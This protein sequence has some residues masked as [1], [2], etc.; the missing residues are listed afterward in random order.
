MIVVLLLSLSPSPNKKYRAVINSIVAKL[1]SA[2]STHYW[3]DAD[4]H[5]LHDDVVPFKGSSVTLPDAS[6][7]QPAQRG[8]LPLSSAFS[9]SAKIATNLPQLKSSS[10]VAVGPLCDDNKLVVFGKKKVIT[11]N[12]SSRIQKALEKEKTL[13]EGIRNTT[14]G[15][16][17][18]NLAK[19]VL[20]PTHPG[21]YTTTSKPSFTACATFS[22]QT[23][24][25]STKP[26]FQNPFCGMEELIKDNEFDNIINSIQ[27][28][29]RITNVVPVSVISPTLNVIICKRTL[30]GDLAEFLHHS[31]FAPVVPTLIKA[32]NNGHLDTFPGLTSNLIRKH[33]RPSIPSAKGHIKQE[34]QNVQKTNNSGYTNILKDIKKKFS[35]LK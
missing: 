29:D 24:M 35:A 23:T 1:D 20:P 17:D 10:L 19:P 30:K 33:L 3:K 12:D 34:R 28:Q 25:S 11:I 13:L 27:K 14:D 16:W 18:I 22:P 26:S 5:L 32:I 2:A 9:D 8:K 4:M 21:L 6:T 31:L 15:C 7:I